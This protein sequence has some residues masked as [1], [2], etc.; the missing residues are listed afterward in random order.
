MKLVLG[1]S[2]PRRLELLQQVGISPDEIRAM[3]IDETPYK[4]ELPRQY[5]QRMSLEKYQA[6]TLNDDEVIVCADTIVAA[7]RRILGKPKDENEA[8]A[9]IKLLSGRRHQVISSVIVANAKQHHQRTVVTRVTMKRLNP[10]DIDN[11]LSTNEWQGKAGGYAIQGIASRFIPSINGSYSNIVGLPL[12]ETLNLL[13]VYIS[14]H[15]MR[16]L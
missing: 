2:S 8:R 4:K 14:P 5:C 13:S 15:K 16:P 10:K 11:Y 7:G 6:T 3:D 12:V 1:S 9:M